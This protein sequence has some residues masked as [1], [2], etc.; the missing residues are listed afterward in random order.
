MEPTLSL[1]SSRTHRSTGT[2]SCSPPV[3]ILAD[4]SATE[5][6]ALEGNRREIRCA[7]VANETWLEQHTTL[8]NRSAPIEV[9]FFV[10]EFEGLRLAA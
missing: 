6:D 2:W 8:W 9:M 3:Q 1:S 7:F 10:W 5:Q 4:V